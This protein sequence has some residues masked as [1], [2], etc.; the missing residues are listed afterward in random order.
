LWIIFYII[1]KMLQKKKRSSIGKGNLAGEDSFSSPSK[2]SYLGKRN[3]KDQPHHERILNE[4]IKKV[5]SLQGYCS[6]FSSSINN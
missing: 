4:G 2:R 5:E 3:L 6:D 1:L